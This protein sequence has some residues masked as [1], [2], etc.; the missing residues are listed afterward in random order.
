MLPS[1]CPCGGKFS[2]DREQICK[3]SG[4]IHMH[5]D[6]VTESLVAYMKELHTDVEVEPMLQ[7]LTG[8][9]FSHRTANIEPDARA[10]IRVRGCWTK[11]QDASFVRVLY[12]HASSYRFRPLTLIYHQLE[13]P[14]R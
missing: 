4:F 2:A 1:A 10:D 7:P 11:S 5:H 6:E 9:P 12:P 14:N 3:L 13:K 8:E